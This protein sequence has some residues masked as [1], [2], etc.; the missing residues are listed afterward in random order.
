M[1]LAASMQCMSTPLCKFNH[2]Q[3]TAVQSRRLK[4]WQRG[5]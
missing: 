1:M 4:A 5:G 2:K 3:C